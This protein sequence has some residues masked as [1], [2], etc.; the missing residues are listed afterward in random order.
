MKIKADI[1]NNTELYIR[2]YMSIGEE[3]YSYHWQGKDGKLIT[4]WD[5]APH[6]KVKT[7]PHH[8]HLST[9]TV[10][11]SFE[12]NLEKVLKIVELVCGGTQ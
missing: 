10:V 9:G 11:E 6:Q 2:E 3:N 5:N 7:F 4:R 8:K 1:K 12:I